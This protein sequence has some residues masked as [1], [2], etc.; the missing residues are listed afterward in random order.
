MSSILAARTRMPVAQVEKP[1]P[2]QA[3]HRQSPGR[4]KHRSREVSR[5]ELEPEG[6]AA[7]PATKL[8]VKAHNIDMV[9]HGPHTTITLTK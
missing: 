5:F 9:P 8:I 2:L 6:G 3:D 1:V 7:N 4:V